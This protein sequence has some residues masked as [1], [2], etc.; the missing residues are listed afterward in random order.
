[1]AQY[2]EGAV[3]GG[4]SI[5]RGKIFGGDNIWRRQYVEGT[6][7]GGGSTAIAALKGQFLGHCY[8]SLV[9]SKGPYTLSGDVLG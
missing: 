4:D 5:W 8:Q 9:F 7:F 6:V 2:L 3:F 1:M